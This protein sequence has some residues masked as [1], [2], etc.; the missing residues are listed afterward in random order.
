MKLGKV[1]KQK[2]TKERLSFLN[3]H[4][5]RFSWDNEE[6][7]EPELLEKEKTRDTD[8]L[9]AEIPGVLLESDYENA[10]VEST[11]GPSELDHVLAAQANANL[12]TNTAVDDEVTGVDLT[13]PLVSDDEDFN[14]GEG[15]E[16]NDDSEVEVLGEN[17]NDGDQNEAIEVT[18]GADDDADDDSSAGEL[19]SDVEDDE[20]KEDEPVMGL[21]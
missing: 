21:R 10:V 7:D 16:G 19:L 15:D 8:S 5:E 1:C 6:L 4:K 20:D 18:D 14:D 13:P 9:L 2:R 11:P 3:R 12:T 17:L